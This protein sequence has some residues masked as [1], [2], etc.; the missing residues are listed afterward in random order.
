MKIANLKIEPGDILAS[1][2]YLVPGS[3]PPRRIV[4]RISRPRQHEDDNRYECIAE[5]EDDNVTRARAMNG[6]DAFEALLL[7]L[8][9]LGIDLG[10]MS[11][12]TPKGLA[13]LGGSQR[14]LGIP[15]EPDFS[16][17]TALGPS[18]QT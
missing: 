11:N 18:D 12:D 14:Y 15:A 8:L 3:E 2:E 13:W 7:G 4:I 5:I 6:A 9:S 16:M 1:R 17:L 10:S